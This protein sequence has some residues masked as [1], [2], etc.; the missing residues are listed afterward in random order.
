MKVVNVLRRWGR[1]GALIMTT[2]GVDKMEGEKV[3]PLHDQRG[4][5]KCKVGVPHSHEELGVGKWNYRWC[6]VC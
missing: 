3:L 1:L 2:I 4:L 5:G 6:V